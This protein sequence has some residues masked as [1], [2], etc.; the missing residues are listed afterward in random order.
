MIA[1]SYAD[2]D[3]G[4]MRISSQKTDAK[5]SKRRELAERGFVLFSTAQGVSL[6]PINAFRLRQK[7]MRLPSRRSLLVAVQKRLH[8]LLWPQT[9]AG[10]VSFQLRNPEKGS[11][12]AEPPQA[13]RI[14]CYLRK[15][16][17]GSLSEEVKEITEDEKIF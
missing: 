8:L 1:G 2:D 4:G 16:K 14:S 12:P 15:L 5:T 6:F 9:Q 11:L 13:G 10:S 7:V 3:V 17:K